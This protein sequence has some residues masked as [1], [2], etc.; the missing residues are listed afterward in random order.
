MKTKEKIILNFCGCEVVLRSQD[1]RFIG[2]AEEIIKRLID[3][4]YRVPNKRELKKIVENDLGVKKPKWLS[5][6]KEKSL[7]KTAG[8]R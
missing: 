7:S 3:K 6:F 5:I 8:K 4:E 1:E 2:K